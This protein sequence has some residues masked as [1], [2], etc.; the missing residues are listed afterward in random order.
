M[1]TKI[2]GVPVSY[3]DLVEKSLVFKSSDQITKKS[4][5]SSPDVKIKLDFD[6]FGREYIFSFYTLRDVLSSLGGIFAFVFTIVKLISPIFVLYFLVELSKVIIANYQ[7]SYRNELIEFINKAHKKLRT[8]SPENGQADQ[9]E[10]MFSLFQP[11]KDLFKE[12]ALKDLEE[13]S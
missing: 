8:K 11:G 12:Y 13:F 4:Y 6:F 1:L 3:D 2:L 10:M 5:T 9:V 7:M